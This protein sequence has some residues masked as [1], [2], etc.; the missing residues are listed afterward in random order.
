M[1]APTPFQVSLRT[2]H[3]KTILRVME[4]SWK[5]ETPPGA[6]FSITGGVHKVS[7]AVASLV[8]AVS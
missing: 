1:W 4:A 7:S 8:A 2:T 5:L 3:V 6:I